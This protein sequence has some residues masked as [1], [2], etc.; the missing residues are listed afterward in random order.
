MQPEDLGR[1]AP[2]SQEGARGLQVLQP[3][4]ELLGG[5]PSQERDRQPHQRLLEDP[6][7]RGPV[8]ST[9]APGGAAGA[10]GRAQLGKEAHG[11]HGVPKAL[12]QVGLEKAFYSILVGSYW[13]L[14][15]LYDLL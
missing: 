3:L 1:A 4:P 14:T 6:G 12:H 8:G 7:R 11:M 13:V 9:A 2:E 5:G 15:G 10:G